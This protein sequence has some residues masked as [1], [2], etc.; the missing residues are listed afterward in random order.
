M[1]SSGHSPELARSTHPCSSQR[2]QGSFSSLLRT[3]QGPVANKHILTECTVYAGI[4][5]HLTCTHTHTHTHTHLWDDCDLR[6]Q[7]LQPDGGD[8][9]AVNENGPTRR[10]DDPEQSQ[11]ERRFPSTGTTHDTDLR[12]RVVGQHEH[13]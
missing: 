6:S 1:C 5:H 13:L 12:E 7:V 2:G 3:A 10:L 11:S 9:N 8:V 4:T